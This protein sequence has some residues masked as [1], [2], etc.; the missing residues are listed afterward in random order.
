MY[1]QVLL[2][3][4]FGN[5]LIKRW[6]IRLRYNALGVVTTNILDALNRVTQVQFAD[7]TKVFTGFD[8]VGRRVAET[9]QDNIVTRFGYDGAGKL[10]AVT[11]A[12]GVSGQQTVTR[13]EYDEAGNQTAQ[14]D[15]LNRTN[16]YAF[17]NMGRR[18]SHTMPDTTRV[19]TFGYDISGNLIR[20]TNFNGVIITNH[21]DV[22]NQLTNRSSVGGYN[23][24]YKY[25]VN[26]QRTN[27]TDLSGA[28]A[29]TYDLRDR[30]TNK[31]V[32]LTGAGAPSLALNY[33][34]DVGGNLT[35]IWSATSSGVTNFYQ[36]DPLSRLTN[37]LGR[38]SVSAG[39]NFDGIG[40]LRVIRYGSGV[41]N[42]YQ[43]DRLNRLTNVL[44]KTSATTPVT[45]G[46]FYYKLGLSGMRTNLDE[47]LN[48]TR[49]YAWQ[50]DAR[51]RLTNVK[52][53]LLTIYTN[54]AV[55]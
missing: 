8:A 14:I 48:G 41:T 55:R 18:I 32:T 53:S 52:G 29:Y 49:S 47:T 54:P 6:H 4:C 51:Y 44:W 21:Y 7:G 17:D 42:L 39:Y 5:L 13:Y 22:L 36:Y 35:N 37:V 50:Y 15:A 43:Y 24:S 12:F 3:T 46:S 11:N 19:E 31:V 26:G 2:R 28:T 38:D 20:Y 1:L 27:M 9:N 16:R 10:I 25:S 40:N 33:R 23:I 45:L 30:L 34:Y